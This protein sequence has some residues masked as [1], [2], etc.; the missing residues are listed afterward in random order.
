MTRFN[1]PPAFPVQ[2]ADAINA[3]VTTRNLMTSGR[4][5]FAGVDYEWMEV[6]HP[7]GCSAFAFQ[8]GDTRVV[9]SGDLEISRMD[10]DTLLQFCE[11]ADLL[12]MDAQFTAG[13]YPMHHG[14]GHSTNL[15][16]AGIA[17]EAGVGRLLLTHHDLR[18]DDTALLAMARDAREVFSDTDTAR[19]DSVVAEGTIDA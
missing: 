2:L 8:I 1:A 10:R 15:Q 19:C 3:R 13:Q 4:D 9:F 5:Q 16:A 17:A 18:H 14:W 11:G 6:A 7:G 12:I